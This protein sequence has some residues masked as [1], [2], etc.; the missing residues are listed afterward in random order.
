M[1]VWNSTDVGKQFYKDFFSEKID[2][3]LDYFR[4][5]REKREIVTT[6][7]TVYPLHPTHRT[8]IFFF[9]NLYLLSFL[10]VVNNKKKKRSKFRVLTDA[11]C[12]SQYYYFFFFRSECARAPR[13]RRGSKTLNLVW[14]PPE[15]ACR[16]V[17]VCVVTF[18]VYNVTVFVTPAVKL[19]KRGR[20]LGRDT[21]ATPSGRRYR[22]IADNSRV[23][24]YHGRVRVWLTTR[25][26]KSALTAD[27]FFFSPLVIFETRASTI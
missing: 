21:D 9:F 22:A 3:N 1:T 6:R 13:R 20:W 25:S 2:K 12:G 26:R 5:S 16:V 17:R 27:A 10:L 8:T 7:L 4:S 19:G 14:N 23:F 24:L 11:K 18:C 15:T